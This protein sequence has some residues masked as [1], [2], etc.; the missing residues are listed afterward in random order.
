VTDKADAPPIPKWVFRRPELPNRLAIDM[1]VIE[2]FMD[3]PIRRLP[4]GFREVADGPIAEAGWYVDPFCDP[5]CCRPRGPFATE[6]DAR[7]WAHRH[8]AELSADVD[9][10]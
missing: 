5:Q 8:A 3:P 1:M 4:V 7:H 6:A 9:E 10:S 2:W